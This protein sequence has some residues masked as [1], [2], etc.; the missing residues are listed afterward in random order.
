[1]E[2]YVAKSEQGSG[3]QPMSLNHLQGGFYFYLLG[4]AIS[5]ICF[6]TEQRQVVGHGQKS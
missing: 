3:L 2:D 1:M 4:M 5:I 6:I